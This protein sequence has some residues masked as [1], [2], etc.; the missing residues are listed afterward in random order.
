MYVVVVIQTAKDGTVIPAAH[1]YGTLD[2]AK[3]AYYSELAAGAS[4]DTL[5]SDACLVVGQTGGVVKMECVEHE[6]TSASG[7]GSASLADTH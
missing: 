1:K 4:S 5:A 3:S 7:P 6:A 2:E